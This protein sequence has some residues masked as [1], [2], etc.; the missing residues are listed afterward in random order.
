MVFSFEVVAVEATLVEVDGETVAPSSAIRPREVAADLKIFAFA[1]LS[2]L[3]DI[4]DALR[5]SLGFE[6]L[7]GRGYVTLT[8]YIKANPI[9]SSVKGEIGL[10]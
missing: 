8:F 7:S 5:L 9:P 4:W 1:I 10:I 6:V 3:L 2:F